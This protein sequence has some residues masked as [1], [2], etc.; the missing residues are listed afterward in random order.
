[1]CA[2]E[3]SEQFS[4]SH[5][6]GTNA[7][8]FRHMFW[9][10]SSWLVDVKAMGEVGV[11]M[12]EQGD[13]CKAFKRV[14][15]NPI[16]YKIWSLSGYSA[17][18]R[19]ERK[20]NASYIIA[21]SSYLILGNKLGGRWQLFWSSVS[22]LAEL[23]YGEESW[24]VCPLSQMF[25]PRVPIKSSINVAHNLCPESSGSLLETENLQHYWCHLT[26]LEAEDLSLNSGSSAY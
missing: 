21:E 3:L 2:A 17:S 13:H 15:V 18:R 4:I 1:M 25:M 7:R 14:K 10:W 5:S 23:R 6:A 9:T 24:S 16:V 20:K 22:Q 11:R 19:L 26:D 12:G 8:H